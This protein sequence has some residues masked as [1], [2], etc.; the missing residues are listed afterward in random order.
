MFRG[1]F[2]F[3]L[4]RLFTQG[5]SVCPLAMRSIKEMN[6]FG[7]CSPILKKLPAFGQYLPKM[8][9]FFK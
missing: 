1:F 2:W 8:E 5:L 7:A 9:M 4:N 6:L 3:R